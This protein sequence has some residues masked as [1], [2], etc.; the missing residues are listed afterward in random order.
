M[1][2]IKKNKKKQNNIDNNKEPKE[3]RKVDDGKD[4]QDRHKITKCLLES[5]SVKCRDIKRHLK[6]HVKTN[7]IQESN[8]N[9]LVQVKK[10]QR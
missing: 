1:L 10:K 6:G 8:I 5:C 4:K 2:K 7:Q 3:K 9:K